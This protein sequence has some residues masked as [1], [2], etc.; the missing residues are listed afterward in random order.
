MIHG[1]LLRIALIVLGLLCAYPGLALADLAPDFAG[2]FAVGIPEPG[3]LTLLA[4]G[5]AALGGIGWLRR[6][7]K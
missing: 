2:D 5:V 3:T 4:S 6:G 7:K 1:Q